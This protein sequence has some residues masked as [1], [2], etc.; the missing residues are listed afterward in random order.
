MPR[1]TRWL[2]AVA[3]GPG[4]MWAAPPPPHTHT[5]A[6]TR[7]H[8]HEARPYGSRDIPAI[9]L[10]EIFNIIG[11]RVVYGCPVESIRANAGV[12]MPC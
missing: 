7:A 5:H 4:A 2:A 8:T 3:S 1:S 12:S 9:I 11:V 6:R 10:K